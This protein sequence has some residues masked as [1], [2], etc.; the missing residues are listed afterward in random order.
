MS[1][2]HWKTYLK[3]CC[4]NDRKRFIS[5]HDM[6]D[7]GLIVQINKKILHPYGLALAYDERSGISFGCIAAEDLEWDYSK[8]RRVKHK[9]RYR[10]FKARMCALKVDWSSVDHTEYEAR[11]AVRN[12]IQ[13]VRDNA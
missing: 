7:A 13:Q 4:K 3:N 12:V 2:K 1:K 5:F 9:K 11:Q 8:K 10:Q 6:S